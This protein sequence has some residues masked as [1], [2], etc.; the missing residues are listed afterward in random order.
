M[1]D[2]VEKELKISETNSFFYTSINSASKIWVFAGMPHYLKLLR[3]H[4]LDK[5]FLLEDGTIINLAL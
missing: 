5:G 4:F 2:I 1:S 3:N